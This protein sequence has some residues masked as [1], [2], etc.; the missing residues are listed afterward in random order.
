MKL[1]NAIPFV[2]CPVLPNV[3][4]GKLFLSTTCDITP[5]ECELFW[6]AFQLAGKALVD[7]PLPDDQLFATA[8]ITDQD[9]ITLNIEPNDLGNAA[10]LMVYPIHRWRNLHLS[11]YQILTCIL[12]EI[13]H[14]LWLIVDEEQVKYKVLE[15]ARLYDPNI[16]L[17]DLYPAM[18]GV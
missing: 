8:I 6:V 18:P 14:C 11:D 16:R 4:H 9:K 12:E 10:R 7:S 5:H 3:L 2:N 15:L 1:E 13:A 17:E